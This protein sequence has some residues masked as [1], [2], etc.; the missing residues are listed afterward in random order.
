MSHPY[1]GQVWGWSPTLGKVGSWSPSGLLNVQ[2]STARGKTPRIG[3]FLVLLKRSWKVD[4]KIA[5][6]WQFEH[7]QPKLWVKERLGVKLAVWLLTTKS[8]EFG[9]AT[10]RWKDLDE[11]YNFGSNL[12][13]IQLC[14]RELWR[15]KVLGVP[16]G[17]FRD[18]ISGVLGICAIWM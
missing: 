9:S 3:M 14:S 16:P 6:H 18:S 17:Q 5:S 2:S 8:R 10:W 13:V 1:F 4:I 11:G 15:F 12:V 7:L